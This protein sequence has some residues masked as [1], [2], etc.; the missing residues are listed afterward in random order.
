MTV[1]TDANTIL[2]NQS[3]ERKINIIDNTFFRITTIVLPIIGDLFAIIGTKILTHTVKN[4]IT[5]YSL[6]TRVFALLDSYTYSSAVASAVSLATCLV[7]LVIAVSVPFSSILTFA[8]IT[9]IFLYSLAQLLS[10]MTLFFATAPL[11]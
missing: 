8:I 7:T 6:K 1:N 2:F 5:E 3:L 9:A 4:E 11:G 10:K